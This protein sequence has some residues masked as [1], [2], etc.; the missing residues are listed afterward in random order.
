[1][2]EAPRFYRVNELHQLLGIGRSTLWAW[3]KAGQFPQPLKLSAGITVWRAEDVSSWIDLKTA[4]DERYNV[5]PPKP[6]E[7]GG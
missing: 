1:M 3:V 7:Q 6:C 4:T 5:Q 2:Q